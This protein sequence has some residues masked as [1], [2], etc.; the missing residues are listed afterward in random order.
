MSGFYSGSMSNDEADKF[1][2]DQNIAYVLYG[3]EER[4]MANGATKLAYPYLTE[5]F[6]N[7][8]TVLYSIAFVR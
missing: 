6:K 1:L 7:N 3:D 8:D 4:Q 5:A 2:K